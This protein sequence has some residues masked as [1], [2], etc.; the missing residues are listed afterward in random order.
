M[1]EKKFKPLFPPYLNAGSK[2]TTVDVFQSILCSIGYNNGIVRDGEYGPVTTD[3]VADL[4]VSFGFEDEDVD[5]NFGPKTRAALKEH[6]G[7]N[8]DAIPYSEKYD[9]D[10]I[11]F[12]PDTDGPQTW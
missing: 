8:V 2:G 7:I 1:P 5:G 12:G 4:Q 6:W 9:R 3:G 10:N 11:W